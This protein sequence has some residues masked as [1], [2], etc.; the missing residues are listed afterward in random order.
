MGGTET[1]ASG[2]V[3]THISR[4]NG[5]GWNLFGTGANSV[6][7]T[8]LEYD[9]YLYMAGGFSSVRGVDNANGLVRRASTSENTPWEPVGLGLAGGEFGAPFVTQMV[10]FNGSLI[11][12]GDFNFAGGSFLNGIARWD[13]TNWHAFAANA[14]GQMIVYHNELYAAGTFPGSRVGKLV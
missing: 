5:S 2:E 10:V 12:A 13:G 9:G 14:Q 7:M 3:A 11:V 6:V 8:M 4:W 1:R